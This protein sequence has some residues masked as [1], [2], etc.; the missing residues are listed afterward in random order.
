MAPIMLATCGK[1]VAPSPASPSERENL[2]YINVGIHDMNAMATKLAP[3]NAQTS[4][5][6]DGV[7]TSSPKNCHIGIGRSAVSAIASPA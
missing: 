7:R 5:S 1:S 6:A 3:K 2:R 4:S